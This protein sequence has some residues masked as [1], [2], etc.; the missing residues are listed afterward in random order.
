VELLERDEAL[1]RLTAAR[2]D[3]AGP[4]RAT[5]AISGTSP[6]RFIGDGG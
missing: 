3:A 1:A 2:A 5:K 6:L 4:S